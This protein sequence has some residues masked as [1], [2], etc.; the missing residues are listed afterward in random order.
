MP[1]PTFVVV[2]STVKV[3][4]PCNMSCRQISAALAVGCGSTGIAGARAS[5]T[6]QLCSAPWLVALSGSQGLAQTDLLQ[7]TNTSIREKNL[8][9]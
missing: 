1:L 6:P 8:S 7:P 2:N 4:S 9:N 5:D 3:F